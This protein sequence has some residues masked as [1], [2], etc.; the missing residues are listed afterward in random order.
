MRQNVYDDPRFF[1]EYARMREQARGLHEAVVVPALPDLLPDLTGKRG[2][3]LGCGDGWFCRY[4][5]AAGARAVVGVASSEGM[6]EVCRERTGDIRIS[7]VRAFAEEVEF[8]AASVDVVVSVLALHYVADLDPV[9][10]AIAGWLDCR[11]SFVK[12][13]EHPIFT[14]E[15]EKSG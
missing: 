5:A 10:A 4:A 8:P 14:S 1:G 6:L 9:L 12:I 2:V 3:D 11:G 15:R 7:Y 13:V